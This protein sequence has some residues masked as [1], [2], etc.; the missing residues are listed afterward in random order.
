[1]FTFLSVH[2]YYIDNTKQTQDHLYKCA[3]KKCSYRY[4]LIQIKLAAQYLNIT[5]FVPL[6]SFSD[7]MA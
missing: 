2:V 7:K 5:L 6:V 1:M 4:F 3:K